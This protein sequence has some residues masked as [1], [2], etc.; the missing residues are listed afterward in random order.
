ML[1]WRSYV[2][3]SKKMYLG[4]HVNYPIFCLILT[5]FSVYRRIFIKLSKIKLQG[6]PSGRSRADMCLHT[7]RR[8]LLRR[9]LRLRERA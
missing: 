5:K 2:A 6:N 7:V 1:L 8:S 4:L 9:Y 3:G